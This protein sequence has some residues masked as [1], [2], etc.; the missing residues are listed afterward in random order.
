MNRNPGLGGLRGFSNDMGNHL[1]N[2]SGASRVKQ[3]PPGF[4]PDPLSTLLGTGQNGQQQNSQRNLLSPDMGLLNLEALTSQLNL[5]AGF[6][7]PNDLGGSNGSSRH[8]SGNPAGNGFGHGGLMSNHHNGMQQGLGLGLKPE[9]QSAMRQHSFLMEKQQHQQQQGGGGLSKDWQEGLRALLPNVNVTFGALP[10]GPSN[11][12]DRMYPPQP[13]STLMNEPHHTHERM[14]QQQQQQQQQQRQQQQH[15][16]RSGWNSIKSPHANDWT[17]L[18]PAIV[19]GQMA[20]NLP[21]HN[22]GLRSESPSGWLKSNLEQLTGG[23]NS[24][25]GRFGGLNGSGGIPALAGLGLGGGHHQQQPMGHWQPSPVMSNTPPPGFALNRGVMGMQP[26]TAAV[27]QPHP[28]STLAGLGG[29][30][31][32]GAPGGPGVDRDAA[33]LESELARLVRS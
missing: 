32:A 30:G 31:S 33:H 18:D 1:N 13:Q 20:D 25:G 22:A 5:N 7:H 10:H 8:D 14:Q 16:S 3:P 15:Q 2:T 29:A 28:F 17:S 21:P 23:D 12:T 24:L 4:A 26:P 11:G 6:G 9:S 27:S 19:S